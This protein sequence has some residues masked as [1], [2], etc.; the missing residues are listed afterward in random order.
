SLARKQDRIRIFSVGMLP[1]LVM[2][3]VLAV[4]LLLE[5]DFGTTVVVG[6][7]T[8]GLLFVAGAR[9]AWL[10][11]AAAFAAPLAAVL[12]GR[13]RYRLQRVLT[14]LGPWADPRGHDYPAVAPPPRVGAGGPTE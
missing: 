5:P 8:F 3:G 7:V 2:L 9:L 1:H 12:V 4:L 11:G 6:C 14:F 13:S 10:A